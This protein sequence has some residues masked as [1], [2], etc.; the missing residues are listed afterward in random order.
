MELVDE[1]MTADFLRLQ[2]FQESYSLLISVLASS[3]PPII[4][5]NG[6]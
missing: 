5:L 6:V 3:R 4:A 1:S 2:L